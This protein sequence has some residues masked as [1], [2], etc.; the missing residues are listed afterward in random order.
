MQSPSRLM[1]FKKGEFGGIDGKASAYY[2]EDKPNPGLSPGLGRSPGEEN[3]NPLQ[4]S[5]LE[6]LMDR[7]AWY[8]GTVHAVAKSQRGLSNFTFLSLST[9]IHKE[10]EKKMTHRENAT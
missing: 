4:Y 5:C 9:N 6:N 1:P 3:G 7:G 8:N 10:R 2:A